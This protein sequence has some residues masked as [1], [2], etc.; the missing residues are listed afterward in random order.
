M[1]ISPFLLGCSGTNRSGGFF[2]K[3]TPT[4]SEQLD[5]LVKDLN[6]NSRSAA[7]KHAVS[8]MAK[9]RSLK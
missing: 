9:A 1:Y 4:Q 6:L 5:A 2:V 3:F 8:E 7:I